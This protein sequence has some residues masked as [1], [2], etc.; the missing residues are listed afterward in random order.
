MWR[1]KIVLLLFYRLSNQ[2]VRTKIMNC[3]ITIKNKNNFKCILQQ[4]Q[5]TLTYVSSTFWYCIKHC[6]SWLFLNFKLIKW[7]NLRINNQIELKFYKLLGLFR[8]CLKIFRSSIRLFK[9]LFC[10]LH[11][12]WRFKLNGSVPPLFLLFFGTNCLHIQ[13]RSVMWSCT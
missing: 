4:D 13:C 7:K 11:V 9:L 3:Q 6:E 2:N 1:A 10:K 12:C 8:M 5:S